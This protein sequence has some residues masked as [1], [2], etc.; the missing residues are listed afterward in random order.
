LRKIEELTKKTAKGIIKEMK[1]V[2]AKSLESL[3]QEVER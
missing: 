3:N 2:G 1:Q